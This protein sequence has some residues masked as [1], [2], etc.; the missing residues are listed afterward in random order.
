MK[1]ATETRKTRRIR[2]DSGL[3]EAVR[4]CAE[5]RDMGTQAWIAAAVRKHGTAGVDAVGVRRGASEPVHVPASLDGVSA[6]AIR[7]AMRAGVAEQ[8]AD[9]ERRGYREAIDVYM[10]IHGCTRDEAERGFIMMVMKR[11]A[12]LVA[13]GE[14]DGQAVFDL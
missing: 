3:F 1:S 9:V 6:T 11:R 7:A 8:S 4:Q 12:E 13:R 2:V 14:I 10:M 5:A